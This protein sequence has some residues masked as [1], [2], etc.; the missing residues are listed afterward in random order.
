V[1]ALEQK[2]AVVTGAATGIGRGIATRLAKEGA[3]VAILDVNVAEAQKTAKMVQETGRRAEVYT[4]DVGDFEAVEK[5]LAAV[6]ASF[7]R[8]DIL[9]NN[10]GIIRLG[11]VVDTPV[12]DWREVFRVNVD[13]VFHFMRELTPVMK[14]QRS[15]SIVCFTSGLVG[16]GWPGAA[17]YA[18]SKGA[19]LGLAKCAAV[20]LK[21]HGVRV[22]VLSPGLVGTPIWLNVAD[23]DEIAMYER[24][25]GVSEPEAVVPSVLYLISD[26]SANLTG[27]VM[28][29]R[30]VPSVKK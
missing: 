1:Y 26:A 17:A 3:N 23:A 13:G 12:K 18:A 6:V 29:R 5:A 25:I 8:I 16:M 21:D 10:A 14:R 22:N 9:V 19:L 2:I 27:T 20:E 4:V 24:S 7:G 15:G 30:L 11:T 28:E